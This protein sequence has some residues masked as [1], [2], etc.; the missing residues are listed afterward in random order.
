MSR[1]FAGLVIL[2]TSIQSS[3]LTSAQNFRCDTIGCDSSCDCASGGSSGSCL[4]CASLC[5]PL[6]EMQRSLEDCGVDIDVGITQIYQGVSSGGLQRKF[7][8]GRHGEYDAN[9]DFGK[10]CGLHGWSL[11]IGSEHRVAESVNRST[12]SVVP[13]ALILNLPEPA[14]KDLAITQVRFGYQ[15]GDDVEL[16]FGKIDTLEYDSNE[17]ADGK[18][19]TKFLDSA[20]NYNPVATRT[21][22]FSTLGAG[23]SLFHEQERVFTLAVLDSEDTPTTVGLSD[24]FANGAVI[25]SELRIPVTLFGRRGHQMFGGSWS[26]ATYDSLRQDGRLDF[27]DIPIAAQ[28]GSWALFWNADQYIWQDPCDSSRGWGIFGRAGISDGNP[29][30]IEWSLSLGVGGHSLLSGREDDTFGVGWYYTGISDEF[31][32][33]LSTLMDDGQG[34][35]MYYDI[36]VSKTMRLSFDLQVVDPNFITADTAVVPGMRARADF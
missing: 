11:A 22:P 15:A 33:V 6:F 17:F 12:G 13:T 9:L 21:I 10:I 2:V 24:L 30:P 23:F 8:F 25:M 26:S 35:E 19:G 27:P 1:V 34:V 28:D 20:F 29:N 4:P 31:G 5:E 36:A 16:F 3:L 18:G 14:T 32:P 7:R